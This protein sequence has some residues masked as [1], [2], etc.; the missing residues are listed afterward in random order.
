[1]IIALKQNSTCSG[2][3]HQH[4]LLRK[5]AGHADLLSGTPCVYLVVLYLNCPFLIKQASSAFQASGPCTFLCSVSVFVIVCDRS[6]SQTAKQCRK[7]IQSSIALYG[8][9][10]LDQYLL[11]LEIHQKGDCALKKLQKT[12]QQRSEMRHTIY[13]F[14]TL[15]GQP[16]F[17]FNHSHSNFSFCPVGMTSAE[18]CKSC[19]FSF[20]CKPLR[21]CSLNSLFFLVATTSAWPTS[22]TGSHPTFLLLLSD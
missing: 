22:N 18:I 15:F 6:F 20:C 3:K 13:I 11:T 10:G 17:F 9:F 8:Q 14:Y 7:L 5:L 16:T 21:S 19:L 4:L 12:D 1:M 2:K